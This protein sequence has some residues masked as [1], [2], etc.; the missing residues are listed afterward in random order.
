MIKS[1]LNK[2]DEIIVMKEGM[3]IEKGTFDELIKQQNYFYNL[4]SLQSESV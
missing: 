1:I 2:Y 3:V 4:Y